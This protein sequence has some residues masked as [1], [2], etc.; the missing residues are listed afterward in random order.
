MNNYGFYIGN[1]LIAVIIFSWSLRYIIK[2]HYIKQDLNQW[3]TNRAD[4]KKLRTNQII[5][6]TLFQ[7][8]DTASVS[9]AERNRL[10]INSDEFT[11]GEIEFSSFVGILESVNPQAGEVFYDLGSGAGKAII[12]AA[13]CFEFSKNCGIELLPGLYKMANRQIDNL[14]HIVAVHGLKFAQEYES[15][16]ASISFINDNILNCDISDADIIFINATCYHPNTWSAIV[17][18]LLDTKV[19]TRIIM[20]TKKLNNEM[21]ENMYQSQTLM[22]WGV[23]SINAYLKVA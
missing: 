13:L 2:P 11:Y 23:N 4:A 3:L 1:L 20:T 16:I 15:K 8:I 14:R 10:N 6:Q 18:K 22:S 19:G 9:K 12:V 21:F 17:Y 5:F 7:G